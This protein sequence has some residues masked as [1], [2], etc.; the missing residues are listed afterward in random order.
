MKN[1]EL[2]NNHPI[3]DLHTVYTKLSHV[4][5]IE[6]VSELKQLRE[7][8]LGTIELFKAKNGDFTKQINAIQEQADILTQNINTLELALVCHE[9][10]CFIK[11]EVAGDT[12]KMCLN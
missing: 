5:T 10:K 12:Q 7:D 1:N 3:L 11:I 9:S 8:Y 4:Q 6:L 2:S